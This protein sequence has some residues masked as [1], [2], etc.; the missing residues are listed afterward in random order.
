MALRRV[1]LLYCL[2]HLGLN[3]NDFSQVFFIFPQI[4][5]HEFLIT[6]YPGTKNPFFSFH[7]YHDYKIETMTK[8]LVTGGCGYIGSHSVV[9]LIQEGYQVVSIDNF[10]NSSPDV[11][12]GIQK[13]TGKRI[14][15]FDIDLA[16]RAAVHA[17]FKEEKNFAGII[18]FAALKSVGDSVRDPI[19]YYRNNLNGMLNLLEAQAM[20][21]ITH[22]IFSSSCSVYGNAKQIPVTEESP[23]KEAASPYARSKQ[24]C[25]DMIK[26]FASQHPEFSFILLRYFNPA[27][28]HESHLIGES[29]SNPAQNLVPVITE[30]A[31][32]KRE[33]VVVFGTNYPTR[34]GSCIR[35]YIHIMDLAKAHTLSLEY[36][37]QR[38]NK[39]G[40]DVF[41]LGIGEGVSVLEA[42]EAFKNSTHQKLNVEYGDRRPGDV[43]AIYADYSKAKQQLGWTPQKGV[44]EIMRD[45]WEWEKRR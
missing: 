3:S 6:I 39:K 21:Q 32:G 37:L 24:I 11:L 44:E 43:V 20:Y 2:C 42:I 36:L 15:N 23:I 27:G 4:A 35:D 16:D 25:E 41:N 31:A 33:K 18:H 26:D 28:A 38:N 8:I 13:I 9:D 40:V 5:W 1:I 30:T 14:K 22:L 7:L 19:A 12:N 29:P 10:S 45:A 17:F 34:D